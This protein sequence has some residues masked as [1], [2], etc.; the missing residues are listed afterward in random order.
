[1]NRYRTL[2]AS[3]LATALIFILTSG[4]HSQSW[5]PFRTPPE[6]NNNWPVKSYQMLVPHD[7]NLVWV[8]LSSAVPMIL[9]GQ[10]E[11]PV[12]GTKTLVPPDEIGTPKDVPNFELPQ[13]DFD[14]TIILS[15]PDLAGLGGTG[16]P[17]GAKGD[18]FR[19]GGQKHDHYYLQDGTRYY[20][21]YASPGSHPPKMEE[22]VG[23]SDIW[24]IGESNAASKK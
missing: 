10:D 7:D 2:R 3:L 24:L 11:H 1:M 19:L 4:A 21:Q 23:T 14:S 8:P 5:D 15:L 22:R 18:V 12:L 20:M 16:F 6:S 9:R 13:I 17:L